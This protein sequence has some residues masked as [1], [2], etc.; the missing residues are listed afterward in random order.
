MPN[1]RMPAEWEK[2]E[3]VWLAWP[4]FEPH[5]P[6]KLEPVPHVYA[7]IIRALLRSEKIFICVNDESMEQAAR[8]VLAEKK[9]LFSPDQL[10][11]FHIPTNG[12]W[13]RD[14]GPIFVYD[15]NNERSIIDWG[16]NAWG[17]HWKYDLDDVVPTKIGSALSIPVLVPKMILEGGSIDVNGEG[18]LLTTSACLLNPDRN[19]DWSQKQIEDMLKE[20]LGI[21]KFLWLPGKPLAGDDTSAHIDSVARFVNKNTIVAPREENKNDEN[22]AT[23]EENFVALQNMTDQNGKPLTIIALPMPDPVAHEGQ[24]L[25]ASY[26]NFYIGNSVVAVPIFNCKKD[27]VALGIFEKLFPDRK[28]VGIDC[29]DLVWGLGTIHCSSQQQPA[30]LL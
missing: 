2:H 22:F 10:R 16:F 6:G 21:T 14:H 25:P 19:T 3:A 26:T 23:L 18:L 11:F 1:Y 27:A 7:E 15:E 24:R 12:S 30:E 17:G 29:T 9:V 5:F 20:Y 8:A 13:I 28:V 4:H